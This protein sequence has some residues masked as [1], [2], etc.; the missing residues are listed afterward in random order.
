MGLSIRTDFTAQKFETITVATG[1][2]VQFNATTIAPTSGPL[3]NN[4]CKSR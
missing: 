2:A 4:V 3:K 1:V